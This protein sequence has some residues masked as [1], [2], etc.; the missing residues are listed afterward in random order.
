MGWWTVPIGIAKFAY[1]VASETKE[2]K[3]PERKKPKTN[4]FGM[5]TELREGLEPMKMPKLS[6]KEQE[7]FN[8]L[9]KKKYNPKSKTRKVKG[10]IT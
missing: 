6:K 8:K 5:P 1:D 2:A 9:F 7:K 4:K 10:D 3:A